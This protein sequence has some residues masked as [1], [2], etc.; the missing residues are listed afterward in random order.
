MSQIHLVG[1]VV[2]IFAAYVFVSTLQVLPQLIA[3]AEAWGADRKALLIS[4]AVLVS[5]LIASLLMWLFHL[6]VA[7]K[8]FFGTNGE[9]A[10]E[11][12]GAAHLESALFSLA[13]L[14]FLVSGIADVSYWGSLIY[15][16]SPGD[17]DLGVLLP[18]QKASFLS[19]VIQ[20]TIG[21][22]LL[23]RGKSFQSILAKIRG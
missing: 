5:V 20:A 22:I 11:L 23:F 2:R 6:T 19:C 17:V 10:V 4:V 8:F 14:W 15:L 18:D 3:G 21:A 9:D 1:V 12:A 16:A 13:G 7:R